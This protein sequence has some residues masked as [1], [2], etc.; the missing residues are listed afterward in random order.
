VSAYGWAWVPILFAKFMASTLTYVLPELLSRLLSFIQS[1]QSGN[2]EPLALGIIL[3]FGMFFASVLN[4]FFMAQYFQTAMNTGIE[5]RTA[6]IAMIYRKS[7]KLSSSARQ[8]STAGEINNHMSVDA[9]RW[10]DA[11]T[12]LPMLL[13]SC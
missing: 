4:S 11:I 12:F 1:Y 3:S 9:E 2:P 7:L 8:K 13:V 5:A 6:L 10:P